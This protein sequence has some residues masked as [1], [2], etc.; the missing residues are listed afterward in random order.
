MQLRATLKELKAARLA[1]REIEIDNSFAEA[2]S[3][4][5]MIR[6]ALLGIPVKL[7]S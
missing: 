7:P 3:Q 5:E 6:A 2:K 1:I 4:R